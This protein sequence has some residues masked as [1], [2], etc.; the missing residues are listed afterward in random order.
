MRYTCIFKYMYIYISSGWIGVDILTTVAEVSRY[1]SSRTLHRALLIFPPLPLPSLS[2]VVHFRNTNRQEGIAKGRVITAR[3]LQYGLSTNGHLIFAPP[4]TTYYLSVLCLRRLSNGSSSGS[5]TL[6]WHPSGWL[7]LPFLSF[8]MKW[9]IP[10]WEREREREE[11]VLRWVLY[12]RGMEGCGGWFGEFYAGNV[13]RKPRAFLRVRG[14]GFISWKMLGKSF[15]I[16]S[17]PSK[18]ERERSHSCLSPIFSFSGMVE[19]CYLKREFYCTM[20]LYDE[21]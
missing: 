11:C 4:T 1:P 12:R 15:S 5:N 2:L 20:N 14:E 13:G 21:W 7:S 6:S 19:K 17:F 9:W 8:M 10:R 3:F 18:W 16:A